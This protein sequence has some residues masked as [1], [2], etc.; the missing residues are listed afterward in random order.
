MAGATT[1]LI[2]VG[3]AAHSSGELLHVALPKR[4]LQAGLQLC[5]VHAPIF[6]G[7]EGVEGPVRASPALDLPRRL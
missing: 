6:V 7:V 5:D 4:A 3:L 2:S 1:D